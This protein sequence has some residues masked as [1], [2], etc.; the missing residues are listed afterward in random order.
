[1]GSGKARISGDNVMIT[2]RERLS[3]RYG[4]A[5]PGTAN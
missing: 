5:K 1:M 4:A 3:I 2:V